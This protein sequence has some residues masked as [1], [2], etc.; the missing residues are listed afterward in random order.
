MT[1][2]FNSPDFGTRTPAPKSGPPSVWKQSAVLVGG[3][4]ILLYAAWRRRDLLQGYAYPKWLLGIGVATWLLTL[5]LGWNS[6]AGLAK[7]W[8]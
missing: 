4:A 5:F 7:L 1:M 8:A 6:L 2:D 3:F